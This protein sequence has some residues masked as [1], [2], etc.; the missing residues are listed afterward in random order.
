MEYKPIVRSAEGA[1]TRR[2]D[3]GVGCGARGREM[4]APPNPERRRDPPGGTRTSCEE[5]ADGGA[6][7]MGPWPKARPGL[8]EK[9]PRWRA[10]RRHVSARVRELKTGCA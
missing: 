9:P 8:A 5:L 3:G 10:E 6:C 2:R 7:C 1:L 4:N